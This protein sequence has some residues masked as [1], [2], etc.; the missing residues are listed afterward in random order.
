MYHYFIVNEALRSND[1]YVALKE[2]EFKGNEGDLII[3]H[4]DN[5]SHFP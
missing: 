3:C 5:F 2:S 1:K 4:V